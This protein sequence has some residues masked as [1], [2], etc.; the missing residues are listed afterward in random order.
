M[1]RI[2][3]LGIDPPHH[4][5][6]AVTH[7]PV[8]TIS[9]RPYQQ[10]K[11]AFAQL[12]DC[13]H[14][15]FTSKQAVHIFCSYHQDITSLQ[16]KQI[17]AVGQAT[18]SVLTEYGLSCSVAATEQAEGVVDLLNW[19]NP[20]DPQLFWGH[21][22]EARPVIPNYCTSKGWRLIECVLYDPIV[23]TE[24]QP[25]DLSSFDEILFTSPSTVRAFLQ[26]Y[27]SLPQQVVLKA[28]GPVTQSFLEDIQAIH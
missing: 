27:G 12:P 22:S 14:L 5:Q 21:S 10:V 13:S 20:T 28:I 17:V 3:Y 4:I 2:L 1:N 6:G 11:D 15:I 25:I 26:I 16:S 19:L 24:L 23:N 18:A 9:P 7:H 8:I